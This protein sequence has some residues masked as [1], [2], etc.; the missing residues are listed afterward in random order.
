MAASAPA[1]GS[2][3]RQAEVQRS[4]EERSAF[5]M[6]GPNPVVPAGPARAQYAADSLEWLRAFGGIE[7]ILPHCVT[8]PRAFSLVY[9]PGVAATSVA[10]VLEPFL[11]A[12]LAGSVEAWFAVWILPRLL[13]PLDR[14]RDAERSAQASWG[15]EI[16]A[17]CRL[18]LAGDWDTLLAT[19][20]REL[21]ASHQKGG[22]VRGAGP[23]GAAAGAGGAGAP[24]EKGSAGSVGGA[25]APVAGA[26]SGGGAAPAQEGEAASVGGA[27]PPVVVR[28]GSDGGAAPAVEVAAGSGGG[29]GPAAGVGLAASPA[30]AAVQVPQWQ[31]ARF[32][33]QAAVGQYAQ[34]LQAVTSPGVL[35]YSEGLVR[36]LKKKVHPPTPAEDTDWDAAVEELADLFA[37]ATEAFPF[38]EFFEFYTRAVSTAKK[39]SSPS[40]GGWRLDHFR[41]LARLRECGPLLARFVH[42]LACGQAPRSFY[43]LLGAAKLVPLRKGHDVGSEED[44][45]PVGATDPFW[46]LAFRSCVLAET[47]NLKAALVP[48]GQLAIGV[49]GA[50]EAYA[51][52]AALWSE[53][54][55]NAMLVKGDQKNAFQSFKRAFA[56]RQAARIAPRL[57]VAFRFFYASTQY[58]YFP[59]EAEIDPLS[60]MSGVGG[61]QGCPG[62]MAMFCLAQL[63]AI[64]S[65]DV[66]LRAVVEGAAAPPALHLPVNQDRYAQWWASAKG[67]C[68]SA[69]HE[70]QAGGSIVFNKIYADD[71][72]RGVPRCL[73]AVLPALCQLCYAATGLEWK[74][75]AWECWSPVP[76]PPALFMG[77]CRLRAPEEGLVAVGAPVASLSPSDV[78]SPTAA[79]G[80]LSAHERVVD[81]VVARIL[82]VVAALL[83]VCSAAPP[84]R[85][86][87]R[88]VYQ[89][90]LL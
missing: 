76:K 18:A 5:G 80:P 60:L 62:A 15:R 44:P 66:A 13:L 86:A 69:M 26:G 35:P 74:A 43:K 56:L 11:T 28:A 53:G 63:P 22:P 51:H 71:G 48:S 33:T 67:C 59:G 8:Y 45:R 34:A 49:P 2:K 42:A 29:A 52:A 50:T 79:L 58:F 6:L 3:A 75:S 40:L 89:T 16:L 88:L 57:A 77:P 46:R 27:V 30:G 81:A 54:N 68:S 72:L 65:V 90:L 24:V 4:Q 37:Q 17:R 85:V 21:D 87:E 39:R 55:P 19:Y 84:A 61:V 31:A 20:F 10:A 14:R 23:S 78:L 83:A 36:A 12:A 73:A 25:A 70:P 32:C 1:R 7:G 64:L 38:E 47:P 9:I 41:T 82:A